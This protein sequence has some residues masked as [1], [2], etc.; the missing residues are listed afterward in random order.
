MD[1]GRRGI[2]SVLLS[3]AGAVL[4]ALLGRQ[5]RGTSTRLVEL[6][7]QGTSR[8]HATRLIDRILWLNIPW[9][10]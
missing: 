7:A 9:L 3:S 8:K 10:V 6:H 2:V 1:A 5:N 4:P